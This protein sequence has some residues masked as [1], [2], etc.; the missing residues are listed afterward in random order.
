MALIEMF[1]PLQLLAHAVGVRLQE[2]L[3]LIY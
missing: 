3:E 2:F 1:I